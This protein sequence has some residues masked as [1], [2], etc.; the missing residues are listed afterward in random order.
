MTRNILAS[1]LA[2]GAL[3]LLAV[4]LVWAGRCSIPSTGIALLLATAVGLPAGGAVYVW[5][6]RGA[7]GGALLGALV[8]AVAV[9]LLAFFALVVTVALACAD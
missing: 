1:A 4:T 2:A 7:G 3:A 8:M 9:G 6:G 5:A